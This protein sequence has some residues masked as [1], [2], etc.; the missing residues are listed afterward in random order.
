MTSEVKIEVGTVV[1][2]RKG[3]KK[4]DFFE[5]FKKCIL[6]DFFFKSEAFVGSEG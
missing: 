1:L 6:L 3:E 4:M 2:V 5:N